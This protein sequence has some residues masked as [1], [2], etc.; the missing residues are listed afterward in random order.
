MRLQRL[1]CFKPASVLQSCLSDHVAICCCMRAEAFSP[2]IKRIFC[3]W[4]R[5]SL[6]IWNRTRSYILTVVFSHF[7]PCQILV[8]CQD[9]L[10]SSLSL[11]T[12]FNIWSCE[13][14]LA[15]VWH[16]AARVSRCSPSGRLSSGLWTCRL[17]HGFQLVDWT[18]SESNGDAPPVPWPTGRMKLQVN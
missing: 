1:F 16:L 3:V 18:L 5:V 4:S 15:A 8:K 11:L 10:P 17:S 7:R 12:I 6:T 13:N 14:N 9:S 2:R